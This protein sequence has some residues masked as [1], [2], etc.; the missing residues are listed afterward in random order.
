MAKSKEIQEKKKASK[1]AG[2]KDGDKNGSKGKKKKWSKG[3][4]AEKAQNKSYFDKNAINGLSKSIAKAQCITVNKV[5]NDLKIRG[6]MARVGIR[7]LVAQG[8]IAPVSTHSKCLIY[9]TVAQKTETQPQA[10][11]IVNK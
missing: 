6:S 10:K 7:Y 3:R 4:I 11:V 5:V 9:T 1:D 8:L 2:K